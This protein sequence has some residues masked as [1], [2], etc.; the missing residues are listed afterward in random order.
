MNPTI[1]NN[2]TTEMKGD[3]T[4]IL[5]ECEYKTVGGNDGNQFEI[6]AVWCMGDLE[7]ELEHL[8]EKYTRQNGYKLIDVKYYNCVPVDNPCE[9][10]MKVEGGIQ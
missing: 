8:R 9:H 7:C 1:L 4:M 6:G 10:L 5:V 2:T 3:N